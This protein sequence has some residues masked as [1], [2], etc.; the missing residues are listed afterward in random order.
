MKEIII[1]QVAFAI[2]C[3]IEALHDAWVIY[4]QDYRLPQYAYAS[5]K[6]HTYSAYYVGGVTVLIAFAYHEWAL[7][8]ALLM[9]RFI[10]FNPALNWLRSKGFFYLGSSGKDALFQKWF[11]PKAGLIVWSGALITAI[12]LNLFFL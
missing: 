5:K 11:G 10:V 8:P 4:L 12:L 3:Y 9:S 2:M 7:C 6:W 1:V